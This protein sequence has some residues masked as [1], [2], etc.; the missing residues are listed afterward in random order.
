[1]RVSAARGQV[2]E[3]QQRKAEAAARSDPAF[4]AKMGHNKRLLAAAAQD[5]LDAK[6]LRE[7][8]ERGGLRRAAKAEQDI[9]TSDE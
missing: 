3:V 4:E 1:L 5:R 9:I 7:R 2:L 6:K 8:A